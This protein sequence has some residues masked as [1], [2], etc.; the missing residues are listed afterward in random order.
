M[1]EES[2]AKLREE[3]TEIAQLA[4]DALG[5]PPHLTTF[6][7][8]GGDRGWKGDVPVVRIST[9]RA[10]SRGWRCQRSCRQALKESMLSMIHDDELGRL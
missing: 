2:I 7:Y 1:S 6:R 4:L 3:I 9:E 5:L 10:Q 8:S